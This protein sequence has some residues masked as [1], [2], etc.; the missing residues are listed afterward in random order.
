MYD[1][2]DLELARQH[3]EELL[4]EA[5]ERRMTRASGRTPSRELTT[6]VRRLIRFLQ[7]GRNGGLAAVEKPGAPIHGCTAD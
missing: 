7:P 6:P 2:I 1:W 4:R 5:H 3:R